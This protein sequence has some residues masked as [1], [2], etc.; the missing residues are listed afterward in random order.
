MTTIELP[1]AKA[2]VNPKPDVPGE[3]ATGD[4]GQ[5]KCEPQS[6]AAVVP[7]PD[8]GGGQA[9]CV[10]QTRSAASGPFLRSPFLRLAADVV[11]DLENVRN[12]NQNRLRQLTRVG[13][14]ADGLHR[15]FG[16]PAEHPDV[17]RLAT[18]VGQLEASYD[19][20]VKNLETVM[21]AHPLWVWAKPL[22]G[23]GQKQL[24]RLLAAI[25]DPFWHDAQ[26]RPRGLYELNA[27]TGLDPVN[28]VGRRRRRGE[29]CSW[30]DTAKMRVYLIAESVVKQ[31]AQPEREVVIGGVAR[32]YA[33]KDA[34]PYRVVYDAARAKYEDAVHD[35]EPCVQ[36]GSKG[37]PAPVGSDLRDGHKHRRALRAVAKAI[38]KDL[39]TEAR[40]LHGVDQQ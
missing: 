5:R 8:S 31:I 22:G 35:R 30:N 15:G 4:G 23:I 3:L 16:L 19:L 6:S 36:C 34:S 33:A 2:R 9:S 27:Y 11:D 1:P 14:D 18:L 29:Q 10:S 32:A 24:A 38:L 25:G 13:V 40:R 12:A 20:A 39:W 21:K 37:K 17:V 28:G 26:N 7:G